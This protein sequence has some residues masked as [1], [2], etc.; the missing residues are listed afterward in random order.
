MLIPLTQVL[1]A[2]VVQVLVLKSQ[3]VQ[4][5]MARTVRKRQ[6]TCA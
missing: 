3:D 2:K 1:V 6:R 5:M 4:E